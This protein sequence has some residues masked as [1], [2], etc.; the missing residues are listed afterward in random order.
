MTSSPLV[1]VI[2]LCYNQAK[3][4]Q[5]AI[6]SVLNQTYSNVQLIV[7]DD[8]STDNS[9]AV[10]RELLIERP[11]VEFLALSENV[12]NC[13]A[14]NQGL[15][16]AK[17]EFLIDFA[18]DDVLM[19]N[20]I[21]VGV[22]TLDE[23]GAE[24]GV[25]FSDAELISESGER[26]SFH[27]DRIP[28]NNVPQGDIYKDLISRYF[29]CPQTLM[30]T[31]EVMIYLNGYD[32]SL[33]Y[34]DFDFLIRSAREFKYVYTPRVLVKRRITSNAM[35]KQQFKFFSKYSQ[36]TYRVCE[37]ILR[38]NRTDQEGRALTSRIVYEAKLNLRL[39]N[40]GIVAKYIALALKNFQR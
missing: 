31:R 25:H 5:E 4:V 26:L 10:I 3:F 20:R 11:S 29:I 13:K 22:K 39:M 12:G 33:T 28:H 14:F 17:G 21:E 15:V 2:C 24:Y 18:A 19:P 40:F 7:V 16:Q 1:T 8:A 37:K 9:V 38:L 35:S 27:S 30:C 6:D 36:T 32:E 34:E 23:A